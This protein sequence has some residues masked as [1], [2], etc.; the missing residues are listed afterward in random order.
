M[1]INLLNILKLGWLESHNVCFS[2]FS[3]N[4]KDMLES[5][6]LLDPPYQVNVI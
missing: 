6:F 5:V 1:G 4:S 2:N 3:I